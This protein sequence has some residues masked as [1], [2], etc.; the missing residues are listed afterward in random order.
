MREH[1]R[2]DDE[3][4]QSGCIDASGKREMR[5]IDGGKGTQESKEGGGSEQDKEGRGGRSGCRG[6]ES[7]GAGRQRRQWGDDPEDCEGEGEG[8]GAGDA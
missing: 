2:G 5:V 7:S 6:R 4:G 1:P 3:R 8:E